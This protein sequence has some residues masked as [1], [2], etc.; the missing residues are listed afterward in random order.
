MKVDLMLLEI[1]PTFGEPGA[2]HP[3][4]W[5]ERL[6]YDG[7]FVAE[8]KHDPFLP[9]LLAA[10]AT[11][12]VELG[13]AIAVAFARS[14]MTVA[15]VAHD[16]HAYSAGRLVLGLGSQIR[17]H[18]TQRFSMPWSDKPAAQMREYISALRAIWACWNDGAPLDFRGDYYTHTLMTPFFTPEPNPY[19]SPKVMLA[20]VG[21]R[22]TQ[23]AGEVADG[24]LCHGFT[25]E[26]F[27]TEVTLPALEA[28]L[29]RA[30]RA[31]ADFEVAAP[32]FVVSGA[33]D[34]ELAAAATR[35]RRQ[36][37]FYGSTPAYRPVLEVHGWGDLQ[38]ELRDL[39]KAGRWDDM[40]AL[41]DDEILTAFAVVAPPE[42]LAA[43]WAARWGGLIDRLSFYVPFSADPDRWGPVLRELA[44]LPATASGA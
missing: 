44:A 20:G 10:Q 42:R 26:R 24:F 31:R 33:D 12:R 40:E 43:A 38:T 29:A 28:G 30:G 18:I 1:P 14:P 34:E 16:L 4:A 27:F 23:V 17:P 6:G 19:G 2:L 32:S 21:P 7:V 25:T 15:Q 37:A 9:L 36:I 5:A 39:T 8:T 3:A 41:I 13:T 22:M 11:E 35:V